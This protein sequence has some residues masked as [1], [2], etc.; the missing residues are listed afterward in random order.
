[1]DYFLNIVG[2]PIFDTDPLIELKLH[3]NVC[4]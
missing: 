2:L 4:I 3:Y 1:M